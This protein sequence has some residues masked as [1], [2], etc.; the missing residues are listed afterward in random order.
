MFIKEFKKWLVCGSNSVEIKVRVFLYSYFWSILRKHL[1]R[2]YNSCVCIFFFFFKS[3]A[4]CIVHG[5][6]IVQ[7]G[8]CTVITIMNS[9]WKIFFFIVFSFQF[10][11]FSKISGIQTHLKLN[12]MKETAS[13]EKKRTYLRRCSP[14]AS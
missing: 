4:S 5:I 2:N 6:W 14:Y 3:S 13:K 11:I 9:N 7:L 8:K 10:S 1:D 12:V